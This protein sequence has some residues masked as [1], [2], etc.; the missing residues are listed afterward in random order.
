VIA[1]SRASGTLTDFY[2]T[3]KS[4]AYILD[5]DI[6]YPTELYAPC[7]VDGAD[8]AYTGY[9]TNQGNISFKDRLYFY[10]R[11][12]LSTTGTT[13]VFFTLSYKAENLL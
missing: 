12:T 7:V 2:V 4:R 1:I 10:P 6:T 9:V 8:G 13:N 3:L 11:I 5:G